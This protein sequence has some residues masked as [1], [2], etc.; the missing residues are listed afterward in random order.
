MEIKTYLDLSDNR[1]IWALF[2]D[3]LFARAT[4]AKDKSMNKILRINPFLQS[5][6][7]STAAYLEKGTPLPRTLQELWK[8][9]ERFGVQPEGLAF[10][11]EV[12]RMRPIWY[13]GNAAPKIRKLNH[14]KASKCLQDTHKVR[15]TG[16]AQDIAEFLEDPNHEWSENCQCYVCDA[17]WE[18]I[19][20]ESPQK[21]MKRAKDLLDML[22]PKWDPRW[23]QPEDF[24]E[25]TTGESNEELCEF[26]KTLT[27][28]GPLAN[29]F[30]IF[31]E[32]DTH[33]E[34]LDKRNHKVAPTTIQAATDGSCHENGSELAT[35]GAGV[36]IY[37]HEDLDTALRVPKNLSQ[38]N[39]VGELLAT[40]TLAKKAPKTHNL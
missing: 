20:C 25:Q 21:C 22:P 31:T 8:T 19:G 23:L 27:M 24:E 3:D 29:I 12:I 32:G 26:D 40:R 33:N 7:P 11:R 17:F 35:A 10:S 16:E 28:S 13:H 30:R 18:N 36:T 39:Q 15:M 9:A 2:A 5:W 6:Q 4:S 37:G 14:A 1:P 34:T 38:T